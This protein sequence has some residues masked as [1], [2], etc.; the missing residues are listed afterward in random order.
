MLVWL[1]EEIEG[2]SGLFRLFM[3]FIHC[4]DFSSSISTNSCECNLRP[5]GYFLKE[6]GNRT[7]FVGFFNP[8]RDEEKS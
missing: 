5:T 6:F 3:R 2:D 1:L 4:V 8:I 7:I